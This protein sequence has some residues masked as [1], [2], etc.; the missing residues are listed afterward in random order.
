VFELPEGRLAI[1]SRF[2]L[3]NEGLTDR[4]KEDRVPYHVWKQRGFLET[5]AG[6][7]VRVAAVAEEVIKEL[8]RPGV[9]GLAF[10][11]HRMNELIDAMDDLGFRYVRVSVEPSKPIKIPPGEGLPLVDW[12]QGPVTMGPAIDELE[13]VMLERSWRHGGHPVLTMCA[14]NASVEV[15]EHGNRRFVKKSESAR[16]DGIVA[17]AMALGLRKRLSADRPKSVYEL[18]AAMNRQGGDDDGGDED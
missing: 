18:L 1:R 9:V 3:P 16:D 14:A 2:W 15:R 11:R 12:A 17:M 6:P 8:S 13:R 5:T 7:T 10:D 4:E